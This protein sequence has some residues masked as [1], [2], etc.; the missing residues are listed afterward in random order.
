MTAPIRILCIDDNSLLAGSLERWVSVTHEFEWCGW[1]SDAADAIAAVARTTPD[2][3][4]LDIDMPGSDSF[5]VAQAIARD[6]PRVRIVMFSGH[7]RAEFI[8]RA[9]DA[10]AWGY[11][12]KNETMD[13]LG[14]AIRSVMTGHF[15][16]SPE[17]Q[18]HCPGRSK[19]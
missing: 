18:S 1:V 17:I 16:L 4:L 13:N 6:Q 10:G 15:V 7:V 8:D 2:V 5:E 14:S 19:A 3:V 11:I 9:L 12:S